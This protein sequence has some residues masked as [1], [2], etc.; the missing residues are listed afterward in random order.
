MGGKN[1]SANEH[2][3]I[4]RDI[5]KEGKKKMM[6]QFK[7]YIE[8]LNSIPTINN[9]VREAIDNIN[10]DKV[11]VFK[12]VYHY[13]LYYQTKFYAY[14]GND[15]SRDMLFAIA[16]EFYKKIRILFPEEDFR[17]DIKNEFSKI[18]FP[19][20]CKYCCNEY[21]SNDELSEITDKIIKRINFFID[22][23]PFKLNFLFSI[24]KSKQIYVFAF[25][26]YLHLNFYIEPSSSIH[27]YK[28]YKISYIDY[29]TYIFFII[30]H[31]LPFLVQ[32]FNFNQAIN[33]TIDFNKK[34]LDTELITFILS[35]FD[36]MYPHTLHIINLVNF[37]I[38][39]LQNNI[40]FI[41][42][43]ENIDFFRVLVFHN[44]NYKKNLISTVNPNCL[45]IN[46]GGYHSLNSYFKNIINC[47]SIEQF[48]QLTI[49]NILINPV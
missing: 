36:R 29:V 24:I 43:I 40:T 22:E 10:K 15:I 41:S 4:R 3:V 17:L 26:K 8:Y 45:P 34:V 39:S 48:I 31:I 7:S 19:L 23:F 38:D 30:E 25:D 18:S 27:K 28:K 46:Y 5:F 44:E 32:K 35:Y 1:S 16:M 12:K 13:P 42:E 37:Q 6:F 33:I 49:E 14:L 47:N 9:I 11:L 2:S 21:N 20:L